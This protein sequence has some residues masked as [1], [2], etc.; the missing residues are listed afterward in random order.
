MNY[1]VGQAMGFIE[2]VGMVPALDAAD[3]MLKA[4][5]VELISYEN[6]GSTLVTVVVTGDVAACEAAVKAGAEAAS[7]IGKL[8][9]KNVIK[10]PVEGVA[11]VVAVHDVENPGSN[12]A[13][14]SRP[15]AL[16]AIETFG[17]VFVLEAADAMAKAADVEIIGYEN[18]ASGYISILV[19]GDVA[20]CKSAVQA[21][22]KSVQDMGA[23]VYSSVVI[24]HPH[25]ELKKITDRYDI[26][27]LLA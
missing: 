19:S 5:D 25:Y 7:K 8:T 11:S 12:E 1:Q 23:E 16:G 22:V 15:A 21:G 20:A 14:N 10:R 24:A 4:A 3:K 9:A 2:T 27:G 6:I 13:L 18:V 26:A 17:L